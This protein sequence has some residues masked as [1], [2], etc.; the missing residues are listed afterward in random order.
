[1]ADRDV[2]A[3]LMR[4]L[5]EQLAALPPF[6][7]GQ[8]PESADRR[9]TDRMPSDLPNEP[10]PDALSW[11]TT[12]YDPPVWEPPTSPPVAEP[13]PEEPE[14]IVLFAPPID[15]VHDL[16]PNFDPTAPGEGVAGDP[17]GALD[18]WHRQGHPDTC[19]IVSQLSILDGLGVEV[20]EAELVRIAE[21]AGLYTPG[22]GAT[23]DGM[24]SLLQ[25]FG[26]PV[27]RT[28]GEGFD[29]LVGRL[30]RGE[31]IM[32]GVNSATL[33]RGAS[34]VLDGDVLVEGRPDHA[35]QVIGVAGLDSPEP[36]VVLNDPGVDDGRGMMVPLNQFLSAWEASDNLL[37][38]VPGDAVPQSPAADALPFPALPQHAR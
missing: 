25:A 28:E 34:D 22:I 15:P 4:R 37:I 14:P 33:W 7:W 8:A 19:A 12:A 23:G 27:E 3:A 20:T 5:D 36:V 21:E 11:Q 9:K 13:Q 24:G 17:A 6:N 1:M 31:Q 35:V 16:H 38:A 18:D 10:P 2:L 29:D 26:L 30:E 32:V